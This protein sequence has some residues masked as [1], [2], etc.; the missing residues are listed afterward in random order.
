M[1]QIK[2]E[3]VVDFKRKSKVWYRDIKEEEMMQEEIA[4]QSPICVCFLA[5]RK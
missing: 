5:L 1:L 2:A 3:P 4:M